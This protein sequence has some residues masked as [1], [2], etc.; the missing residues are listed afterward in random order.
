MNCLKGNALSFVSLVAPAL[1]LV[2]CFSAQAEDTANPVAIKASPDKRTLQ[3]GQAATVVVKATFGDGSE[4]DVTAMARYQSQDAKIAAVSGG[5]ITALGYGETAVVAT[6]LH[7]SAMVKVAVPQSLPRG[8]PDPGV[9][10]KIDELVNAKLKELGIPASELCT[11][12]E[13]LRRAF[14]DVIGTLPK[15]EEAR[16]FLADNDPQKRSKL[17]DRLLQRPEYADYWTLKWGDLL[18]M[19]SETPIQMWPNAVQAYRQWV[20]RAIVENKPYD[21]FATELITATG[22][23]SRDP[24]AN[25]YRAIAQLSDPGF[26]GSGK[27][28]PRDPMHQADATAAVFMGV[29]MEC[30]RC[31]AHPTDGWTQDDHL[32]FSA[33]FAQ[34]AFKNTKE[35]KEEIVC[36]DV[37][38]VL[39][40][41][42]TKAIVRPKPLGGEAITLAA[43]E[44]ARVKLA[45]W[46]T[47]PEN[48]WFANC[49]VNRVWYW[50]MGRGIVHEPD[51]LRPTNPPSNPELLAYLA[52]EL[53]GHKYDLKHIFR[54]LLTSQTYQRSS[55]TTQWNVHDR[56]QFSHYSIRRLPAESL[57]DAIT[58]VTGSSDQYG[59]FV[60]Q[61]HKRFPDGTGAIQLDDGTMSSGILGTFGRPSRDSPYEHSRDNQIGMWQ[62]L[63]LC[64]AQELME[65]ISKGKRIGQWLAEKRSDGEIVEDLYLSALSRF[66]TEPE[67]QA[68]LAHL[69]KDPTAR[70]AALEDL[71][72][73]VLNMR[74]FLFN[75]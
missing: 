20:H 54:L 25:Y 69:G 24:P 29:R 34:V 5:K 60:P 9:N 73:V 38:K 27:D 19:K 57:A 18:R 44:D 40:D 11:D 65:K 30:M 1:A 49:A 17:I 31:H 6:Y 14:L 3:K 45:V 42:V 64:N 55:Q 59:F 26:A 22:S 47:A 72:W 52:G 4:K 43:G 13:F 68:A 8:F 51:D 21:R 50:L 74:E 10:N 53:V 58:Q 28:S 37:D 36:L 32:G 63:Y 66:P 62:E 23:S 12:Q 41:P 7:R 75:H 2:A 46:L 71:M 67:K 70:R 16:A 33:F 56:T 15:P 48:P 39:T 35:Y 61:P